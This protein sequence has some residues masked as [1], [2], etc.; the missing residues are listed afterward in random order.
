MSPRSN[1]P[2]PQ[3]GPDATLADLRAAVAAIDARHAAEAAAQA[4]AE[5]EQEAPPPPALPKQS[6]GEGDTPGPDEPKPKTKGPR[7]PAAAESDEGGSAETQSPA[8]PVGAAT[9]GAPPTAT[10]GG[11]SSDGS[12]ADASATESLDDTTGRPAVED[13]EQAPAADA[14][15]RARAKSS[16][17]AAGSSAP[18]SEATR[19]A[20]SATGLDATEQAD[21]AALGS[22]APGGASSRQAATSSSQAIPSVRRV[23]RDDAD[24]IPW[25]VPGALPHTGAAEP[26]RVPDEP[27]AR[28]ERRVRPKASAGRAPVDGDALDAPVD[29]AA[30]AAVA[31]LLTA[32]GAPAALAPQVIAAVG[33][34]AAELL[35]ADPWVLLAVPGVSPEKADLFAQ[36]AEGRVP[37]PGDE[38]RAHALVSWHL[39]RAAYE[40][41]TAVD[42]AAVRDVLR[43]FGV[44]DPGAALRSAYEAGR[45]MA[46]AERP[47]PTPVVEDFADFDE[48]DDYP[49]FDEFGEDDFEDPDF[50]D[51]FASD[52]PVQVALERYAL[53]EES[54]ADA[55]VRLVSTVEPSDDPALTAAEGAAG[56]ALGAALRGAAVVLFAVGPGEAVPGGP[57]ALAARAAA[58]GVRAVVAAPTT[59]GREL[60]R[61]SAPESD[62][63]SLSGLLRGAEG[64][65]R[66]VDGLLDL[67]LL[68]VV[69]AHLLDVEAAAAVLEAL[70][71]G[72]RVVLAGDS[73][74]LESAGPGR[75]FA[76]LRDSGLLPVVTSDGS[77]PGVL[78]RLAGGVRGGRLPQVESP[79]RQVV[80]VA[81]RSAAEAVHRC[82]QLVGDSIPRALGIPSEDVLVVTPAHGGSAGSA[83]LNT[84]LKARLN[85]GPGQFAGF[86]V[87]DRVVRVP[88]PRSTGL[89]EGRVVE[90]VADGLAVAFR[91]APE[92][93]VVVP[94]GR[95]HELRHGWAV[96]VAQASGVR[97]PGAVAMMPGDAAQLLTRPL[98]YTAFTRGTRHLSVV[99]A[100]GGTLPQA[101]AQQPTGA[102]TTRLADALKAAASESG[103]VE[104]GP[105]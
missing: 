59:D 98:V 96:T 101:V 53:A 39:T 19:S 92:R 29:E 70:P 93:P 104:E 49:D 66:D 68:V 62:A 91:D 73:G 9:Q 81:A 90:A 7:K 18:P 2:D 84:A 97:R 32:G 11:A 15:A 20:A 24:D 45:V 100:A 48:P 83:A 3:P 43:H 12:Q 25:A 5:A 103:L 76:D 10:P 35:G 41:H 23:V 94:R 95:L 27:A 38:R 79:D 63:V 47:E 1:V 13:E 99:Y 14:G 75:V 57:V 6:K 30:V 26:E 55:V 50:A 71:D 80:L 88:P 78:G 65:G 42:A 105:A 72:G 37:D 46:F 54:I 74:E 69:D 4:A 64:P 8:E 17:A 61:A 82:V 22:T 56:K 52:R 85:P 16:S 87:G 44:P 40:G 67:D 86:D 28:V 58:E 33:A 89:V 34:E 51:P 21:S 60:L 102:R 31:A 36:E 77:A